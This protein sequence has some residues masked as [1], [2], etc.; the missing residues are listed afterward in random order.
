MIKILKWKYEPHVD[1]GLLNVISKLERLNNVD[2]LVDMVGFNKTAVNRMIKGYKDAGL[3]TSFRYKDNNFIWC[4]GK[5]VGNLLTSHDA[6]ATARYREM[7]KNGGDAMWFVDSTGE[8]QEN[9]LRDVPVF[10]SEKKEIIEDMG[11]VYYEGNHSLSKIKGVDVSS[12]LHDE[13]ENMWRKKGV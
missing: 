2:S 11:Y 13:V 7:I 4:I 6:I 1:N 3:L 8:E 9:M 12:E 5:D 10:D